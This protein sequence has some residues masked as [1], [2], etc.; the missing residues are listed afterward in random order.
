MIYLDDD[1]PPANVHRYE[2]LVAENKPIPDAYRQGEDICGVFYTGGT[3]GF[4]KGVLLSHTN[5]GVPSMV[6][7]CEQMASGTPFCIPRRCS[8]LRRC[9]ISWRSF[10]MVAVTS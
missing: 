3:T 8:T 6:F 1:A 4:P 2:S 7:L 5:I 10:L 9:F